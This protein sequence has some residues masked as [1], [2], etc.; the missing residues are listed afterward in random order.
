MN[1]NLINIFI[2]KYIYINTYFNFVIRV[3]CIFKNVLYNHIDKNKQGVD[4][5]IH[6]RKLIF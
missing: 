3:T 5:W 2:L 1:S 6:M 4:N